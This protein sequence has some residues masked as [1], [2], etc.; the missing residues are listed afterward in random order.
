MIKNE[1]IEIIQRSKP[2]EL[3]ILIKVNY[4]NFNKIVDKKL[5]MMI[6][7]I[8]S[9]CYPLLPSFIRDDID[10]CRAVTDTNEVV[11]DYMPVELANRIKPMVT[12]YIDNNPY[13]IPRGT[14]LTRDYL[15][16]LLIENGKLQ[17]G[18]TNR[19]Y[20]I[21]ND[22]VARRY[23]NQTITL[24]EINQYSWGDNPYI[25]GFSDVARDGLRLKVNNFVGAGI[26]ARGND[27]WDDDLSRTWASKEEPIIYYSIN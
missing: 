27:N 2:I 11:F 20:L 24:F 5:A 14:I 7:N 4:E 18:D 26:F 3:P 15:D 16:N 19:C 21:D 22:V 23:S 17:H 8:N 13:E 9:A 1:F 10:F 25:I 12:I 6:L